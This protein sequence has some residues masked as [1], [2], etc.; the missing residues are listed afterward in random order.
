[1]TTFQAPFP[2]HSN[3][4]QLQYANEAAVGFCVSLLYMQKTAE[5]LNWPAINSMFSQ[6]PSIASW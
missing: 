6:I 4:Y 2:I 1:M 5:T 3:N